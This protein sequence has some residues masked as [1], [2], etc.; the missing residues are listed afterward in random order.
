MSS[1]P[2]V[3]PPII[4][5]TMDTIIIACSCAMAV[6]TL[7]FVFYARMDDTSLEEKNVTAAA[8]D[9]IVK[10]V[11]VCPLEIEDSLSSDLERYSDTSEDNIV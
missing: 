7:A 5:T 1:V 2:A 8:A 3:V 6:A 9:T 11:L 10:E 4:D